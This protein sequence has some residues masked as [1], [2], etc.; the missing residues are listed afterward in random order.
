MN[1]ISKQRDALSKDE[2]VVMQDSTMKDFYNSYDPYAVTEEDRQKYQTYLSSLSAEEKLLAEAGTN[3]YTL[4]LKNKGG[5]PMPV[6]V[7]ME[8]EDG[9]DSV[10]RFPAEIWRFNDVSINKVIATN[11][12]VKQWTLDPFYEIA[13]INTED[14]SF[15]PVAQPTRFQLFKQQQ[16]G[17]QGQNP[18][19]QQKQQPAPARQGSGKN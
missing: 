2:T 9:T 15:P 4:S 12:K 11:K 1:T 7:R 10:A 14:N 6:I 17:G 19:Q 18:M 5:I 3:F 13:D 8:F 16:R